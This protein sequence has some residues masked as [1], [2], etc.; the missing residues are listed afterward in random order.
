MD[1][2]GIRMVSKTRQP[3]AERFLIWP[4]GGGVEPTIREHMAFKPAVRQQRG[5][6]FRDRPILGGMRS[7]NTLKPR[8]IGGC[9]RL[10]RTS[11][12]AR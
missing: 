12:A 9:Q 6:L 3:I 5:F 2:G 8:G 4:G 11:W 10:V 7:K 1:C